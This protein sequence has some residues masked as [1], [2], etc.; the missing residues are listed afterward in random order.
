MLILN[1]IL[2]RKNL[3]FKSVKKNIFILSIF[4]NKKFLI[5]IFRSIIF[6][7]NNIQ[8]LYYIKNIRI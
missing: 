8:D 3:H 5:E 4:Q 6:S 2:S 1:L 7:I